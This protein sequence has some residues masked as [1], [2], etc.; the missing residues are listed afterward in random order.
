MEGRTGVLPAGAAEGGASRGAEDLERVASRFWGKGERPL[1]VGGT[2]GLRRSGEGE[3]FFGEGTGL[4]TGDLVMGAA[5]PGTE[6]EPNG[7]SFRLGLE[8]AGEGVLVL[9]GVE[10]QWA[11]ARVK[12][13]VW[14]G[15]E[16]AAGGCESTISAS[17]RELSMEADTSMMVSGDRRELE[18]EVE[19]EP[20]LGGLREEVAADRESSELGFS[21][22]ALAWAG[23]EGSTPSS[24]MCSSRESPPAGGR[25]E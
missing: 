7:S 24:T 2:S 19:G 21:R 11:E 17:V 15:E 1:T 4:G 12:V 18:G 3:S 20:E 6:R 22:E 25:G 10:A 23:R 16:V 9:G 14:L 13:G 8:E 5:R